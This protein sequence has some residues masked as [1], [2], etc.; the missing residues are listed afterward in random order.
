MGCWWRIYL[1]LSLTSDFVNWR[2]I[3]ELGHKLVSLY[4]DILFAWRCL[5]CLDIASEKLLGSF[6]SLLLEA[7]RVIFALI[8]LEELVGICASGDNHRGIGAPTENTF[9]IHDILWEVLIGVRATVRVLI[10]LFLSDYARV[11]RETLPASSATRLLQHFL[12]FI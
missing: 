9:I 3:C 10:L 12:N 2:L 4:V 8:C 11:C 6:R 7:F 1:K 5:R